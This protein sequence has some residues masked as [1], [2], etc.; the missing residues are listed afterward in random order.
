MAI[1]GFGFKSRLNE[2]VGKCVGQF[3][4][5]FSIPENGIRIPTIY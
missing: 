3:G 1:K 5:P 4:Q 2:F